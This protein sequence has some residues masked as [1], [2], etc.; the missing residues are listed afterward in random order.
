MSQSLDS[1]IQDFISYQ[2]QFRK[3]ATEKLKEFFVKFWEENP[4]IKAVTW[5]QYAPYFNDGN[6]CEFS[7]NDPYFTNAEGKDLEE[8]DCWGGYEGGKEDI[9]SECSF[10]GRYGGVIPEGVDPVSTKSLSSLLTSE[11]MKPIME[12]TFGS[13]NTVIATREGFQVEDYSGS[14]D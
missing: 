12:E 10:S 13:D 4:A 5:V 11:V 9:W 6:A 3:A 1:L 2:E 14:H 8:I 7:V